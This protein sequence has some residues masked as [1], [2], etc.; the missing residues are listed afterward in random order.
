LANSYNIPAVLTL[1]HIGVPA[2]KQFAA[3][4]GITSFTGDFGLALTLGGGEVRLLELTAAYGSLDD[5]R[6]LTPRA[7]LAVNGEPLPAPPAGERLLAPETAWL[8]TDILDDDVARMAAFGGRSVL[9]LPFAAAAKTGTTT[10]W[11][12]NW[13]LGYSSARVVGVWVGN[14]DNAPMQD[15]SGIDGAGPIWRDLMLAAHSHAPAPFTQPPGIVEV[16]ICAPSGLLPT[17]HC[18]RTRLESFIAGSEPTRPDDQFVAVKVDRRTGHPASA[19]TPPEMVTERVYW[20]LP[21]QYRE[22]QRSQ[23]MALL[24]PPAPVASTA[25]ALAGAQ[26]GP[27]RADAQQMQGGAPLLL[28]SPAPNTAYRLHPG[29]P[30]ETQRM[31]V[32]GRTID[33]APWAR[34]R[35]VA[36][37]P[38][39]VRA[40]L[41]EETVAG[42]IQGWWALERGG[43][44]FVLEGQRTADSPWERSLAAAVVVEGLP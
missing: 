24:P 42:D 9:N 21:A 43:W 15:V 36:E 26:N 18:P 29:Q 6:R 32:A 31:Q 14:A 5:G 2:L 3:D 23:G 44:R 12:D 34:L 20:R 35:L 40:I 41:G 27:A 16:A 38:E 28:T 22:W 1:D 13:T 7:L 37:S 10:D 39:G 30:A 33:G 8:I 11:R 19:T 17:P 4:A 25:V